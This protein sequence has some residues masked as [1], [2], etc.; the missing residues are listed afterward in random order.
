LAL[1][2]WLDARAWTGAERPS[3]LF[4][5][6]IA[7]LVERKVLLPGAT[8]PARLVARV[9]DRVAERLWAT[10]AA[11]PDADQRRPRHMIQGLADIRC[12]GLPQSAPFS[13]AYPPLCRTPRFDR[14]RAAGPWMA[15]SECRQDPASCGEVC[16]VDRQLRRAVSQR[17]TD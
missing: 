16:F 11:A 4:D 2:R 3:V 6:A 13:K 17:S 10:L 12:S 7:R 5:L 1:V 14:S 8:V 15:I 9:S